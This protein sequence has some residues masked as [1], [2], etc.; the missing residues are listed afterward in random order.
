MFHPRVLLVGEV[1]GKEALLPVQRVALAVHVVDALA[2]VTLKAAY[3]G[4]RPVRNLCALRCS[5]H[6][7]HDAGTF[8]PSSLSAPSSA[9]LRPRSATST[10]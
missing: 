9:P 6:T 8:R 7:A 1:A 3:T 4:T 2:T 5:G 10:L